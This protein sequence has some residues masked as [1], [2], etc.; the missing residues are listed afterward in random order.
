MNTAD[1][2]VVVPARGGSK[3]LP[4]KNL[5]PFLGKPLIDWSLLAAEMCPSVSTSILSSDNL[6]YR[7]RAQF[8]PK[9]H[10]LE[11]PAE[12]AT[13]SAPMSGVISHAARSFSSLEFEFVLLLDPT[14]PIRNPDEIED[15]LTKLRNRPEAVGAVSISE[16]DFNA[17]W[18]GVEIDGS[19]SLSRAFPGGSGYASRQE[20]PRLWR[21]NG[22]FYIW[23][24]HFAL[25]ISDPWLEKGLHLGIETP[26]ERA[27]SIDTKRE[28]EIAEIL[29]QSGL[30]D[31][32]VPH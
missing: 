25:D 2:I 26:E 18:V 28:F 4:G 6:E 23:R 3:G 14:S 9:A 13:D 16:P 31:W 5:R 8:F 7:E 11:R 30:V 10:P 24:K 21:M 12:Y 32:K 29:V 27:F 19:G 20:V 15:A 1:T 22:T 17:R